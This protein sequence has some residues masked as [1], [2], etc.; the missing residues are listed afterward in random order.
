MQYGSNMYDF[1]SFQDFEKWKSEIPKKIN[2][3]KS[4]LNGIIDFDK[5]LFDVLENI[6]VWII[7]RYSTVDDIKSDPVVWDELSCYI[8]EV[9]K[10]HIH[11]DWNINL[12]PA[13]ADDVYYKKPVICNTPPPTC[14]SAT[15]TTLIHRKKK[16]FIVDSV[17]K[18][19]NRFGVK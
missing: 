11:G 15:I 3:L 4:R 1:Q 10:T 12:N 8:G 17:K 9:Y 16:S 6:S 7:D 18:Q 2:S 5:P 14:P 19:M 13:N